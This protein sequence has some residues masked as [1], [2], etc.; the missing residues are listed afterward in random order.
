MLMKSL[1]TQVSIVVVVVV[2]VYFTTISVFKFR[3]IL[4]FNYY[5]YCTTHVCW[6]E[7]TAQI[8]LETFTKLAKRPKPEVGIS[9]LLHCYYCMC[10]IIL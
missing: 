8:Y 4:Y 5:V 3:L 9:C 7:F 10:H 2:A 6:I 1:L